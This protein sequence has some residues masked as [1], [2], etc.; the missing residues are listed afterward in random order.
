MVT[1]KDWCKPTPWSIIHHELSTL[2]WTSIRKISFSCWY[3]LFDKTAL[4]FITSSC[5]I[6][7]DNPSQLWIDTCRLINHIKFYL[8]CS[9]Y[10]CTFRIDFSFCVSFIIINIFVNLLPSDN[11]LRHNQGT[12]QQTPTHSPV[13]R[14]QSST[15]RSHQ[16]ERKSIKNK[17][18]FTY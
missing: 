12:E 4:K 1:V 15:I 2:Q 9:K 6:S 7:E 8:S 17:P 14:T 13:K 18:L 3:K 16:I 10:G 11:L 5:R